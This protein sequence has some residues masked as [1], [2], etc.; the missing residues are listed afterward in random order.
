MSITKEN[1]ITTLSGENT[2]NEEDRNFY[3]LTT[4]I[5]TQFNEKYVSLYNMMPL[6][7][8][9][10][11]FFIFCV[12]GTKDFLAVADNTYIDNWNLS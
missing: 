9:N 2:L 5:Y 1:L 8:Q 4:E 11:Y 6:G 7:D 3:Y 12:S 10:S